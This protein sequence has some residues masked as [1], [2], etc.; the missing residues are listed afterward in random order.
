MY[1]INMIF[2]CDVISTGS[3]EQA[4]NAFNNPKQIIPFICNIPIETILV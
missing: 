1:S 2:S 4:K 3:T